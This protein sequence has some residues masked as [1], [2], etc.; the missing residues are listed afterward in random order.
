ML[1]KPN[2]DNTTYQG[3][4]AEVA[5]TQYVLPDPMVTAERT[6]TALGGLVKNTSVGRS[7]MKGK[8]PVDRAM[9]QEI[10]RLQE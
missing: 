9:I 3:I 6:Q 7:Q 10:T 4:V 1:P 8:I 2:G 5:P